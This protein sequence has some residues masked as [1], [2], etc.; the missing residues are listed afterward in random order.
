MQCAQKK[1]SRPLER[2]LILGKVVSAAAHF[3]RSP[4]ASRGLEFIRFCRSHGI[5]CAAVILFHFICSL[6]FNH[7]HPHCATCFKKKLDKGISV[8]SNTFSYSR[9]RHGM[10][11]RNK[12]V[13]ASVLQKKK[14]RLLCQIRIPP[15]GLPGSLAQTHRRCGKPSCHCRKGEGH[16]V[17]FLTFRMEGITRVERIPGS[18][19]DAVRQRVTQGKAFKDA[20]NEMFNLNAD[21]LVLRRKERKNG[22]KGL[23][24]G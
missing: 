20:V 8:C 3:Y 13:H 12:G 21:L 15:E 11:T 16:P 1:W 5:I 2:A 10:K 9:E 14:Q 4:L 6:S 24:D 7:P 18:W 22:V 23:S 17:W 19:V